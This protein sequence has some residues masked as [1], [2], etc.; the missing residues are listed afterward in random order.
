MLDGYSLHME[1]RVVQDWP[2]PFALVQVNRL[3]SHS[4]PKTELFVIRISV[5]SYGN[6]ILTLSSIVLVI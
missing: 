1:L 4:F 2:E 6:K 3:K 5:S